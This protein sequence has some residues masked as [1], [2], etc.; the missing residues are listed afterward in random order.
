MAR[1][2]FTD[3]SIKQYCLLD[4]DETIGAGSVCAIDAEFVALSHVCH[5][6]HSP[7]R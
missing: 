2:R 4:E 6:Y 3:D 1:I 7:T 5:M